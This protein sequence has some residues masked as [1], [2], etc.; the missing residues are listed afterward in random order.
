MNDRQLAAAFAAR[1]GQGSL[2]R[3]RALRG[4]L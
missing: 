1:L 4:R 2:Q 3:L